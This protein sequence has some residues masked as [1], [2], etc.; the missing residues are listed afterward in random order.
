MTG[1]TSRGRP[2]CGAR[3]RRTT[4]KSGRSPPRR[5]PAPRALSARSHLINLLRP[6]LRRLSSSKSP[7]IPASSALASRAS[8]RFLRRLL[9][10][11]HAAPNAGG[12]V[13]RVEQVVVRIVDERGAAR[14]HEV[15]VG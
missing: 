14:L 15:V 2:S 5:P 7:R 10:R 12:E 3:G 9:L 8:R 1:G 11:D 6:S 4:P 13:G